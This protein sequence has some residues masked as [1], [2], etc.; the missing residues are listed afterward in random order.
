MPDSLASWLDRIERIHPRSIELGLDR[1]DRVRLE[2]GLSPSFPVITVGG[3][4]GKGSTCAMLES[5]LLHCGYRVGCYTSPHLLR[6]NERIRI[7][8]EMDTDDALACAFSLIEETRGDVSLTYFEYT[9]LAAVKRFIDSN[10]DVA[11]LEVGLGGRLDA[12]NV[13]DA[14]CA[15]IT[16][17]DFDHMDYLGDT[18]DAIGFEKAGI[19]RPG[20]P[21]ICSDPDVPESVLKH[22]D[23]I[24]A[25]LQKLGRDFGYSRHDG[26]WDYRGKIERRNL[27]LPALKGEFQLANASGAIAAID[28]LGLCRDNAA[29]A[30]GLKELRLPGRFQAVGSN[31]VLDVAHNPQAAGALAGNLKAMPCRGK[32]V[33]IFG[34]LADKDIEGVVRAMKGA[35]EEWLIV[36]L[37]VPRGADIGRLEIALEREGVKRRAAFS[38]LAGAWAHA[39]STSGENDRIV[40][41]GS[42][43]TVAG[44]MGLSPEQD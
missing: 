30:E 41:F 25:N 21:A 32:T 40:V 33:A 7:A 34:M 17:I 12:V 39:C 35:V 43:Y 44:F 22:A 31:L 11:I 29:V 13:F 27:P 2:M 14:D 9:T 4:N 36:G 24:G 37:D 15:V 19:L 42:F 5:I 8:G 3:T 10:V 38:S 20:K 1:M 6:F 18:R 23:E 26:C 16:S 28:A